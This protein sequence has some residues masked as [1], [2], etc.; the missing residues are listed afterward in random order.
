MKDPAVSRSSIF[1][2][3]TCLLFAVA[4][5]ASRLVFVSIQTRVQIAVFCG[6]ATLI[7][8][9]GKR[10]FRRLGPGTTELAF[11]CAVTSAAVAMTFTKVALEGVPRK[12][13]WILGI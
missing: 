11:L 6:I 13:V 12:L 7:Y 2:L 5:A 8:L 4:G 10:H 9:V 3:L 1:V